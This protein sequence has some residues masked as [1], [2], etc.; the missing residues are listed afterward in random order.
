MPK[1]FK[2]GTFVHNNT[3]DE[4]DYGKLSRDYKACQGKTSNRCHIDI[5]KIPTGTGK[6]G[7]HFI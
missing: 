2:G 1:D 5:L 3:G 6:R 4:L 7:M